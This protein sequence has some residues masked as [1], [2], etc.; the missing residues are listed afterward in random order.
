MAKVAK[1]RAGPERTASKL[2]EQEQ[3]ILFCAAVGID[4][5]AVRIAARAM[6]VMAYAA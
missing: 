4:H 6:Q 5:A 2:M 3:V 1:L